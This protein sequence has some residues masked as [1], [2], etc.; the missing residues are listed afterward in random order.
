MLPKIR[1]HYWFLTSSLWWHS[2]GIWEVGLTIWRALW[3][4]KL[5]GD[6]SDVIRIFWVLSNIPWPFVGA[7]LLLCTLCSLNKMGSFPIRFPLSLSLN[8]GWPLVEDQ[9]VGY[10]LTSTPW[11]SMYPGII[12]KTSV[13]QL[14]FG[15][16]LW[17][18]FLKFSRFQFWFSF[19]SFL[20]KKGTQ[21]FFFFLN[22]EG[23][24]HSS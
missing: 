8:V 5:K 16:N 24:F 10:F 19:F 17:F 11:T 7:W 4:D 21:F 18:W 2:L 12:E 23:G 22:L 1:T 15:K 14:D 20:F 13:G 9:K 3:K 6:P